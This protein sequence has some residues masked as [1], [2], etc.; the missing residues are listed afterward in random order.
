MF[1]AGKGVPFS[2]PSFASVPLTEGNQG[3]E[4]KGENLEHVQG[5][6]PTT[7]TK[8]LK[9]REGQLCVGLIRVICAICGFS[10]CAQRVLFRSHSHSG[11]TP[12]LG[13]RFPRPRG[14]LSRRHSARSEAL[15]T[16]VSAQPW[17]RGRVQQHAGRVCSPDSESEFNSLPD[18]PTSWSSQPIELAG[19]GHGNLH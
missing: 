16:H 10:Y 14:K 18:F 13:C 6:N 1:E 11:S 9:D 2:P 5:W 8:E 19:A 4:A 12:A 17:T 7:A 15:L 3:N